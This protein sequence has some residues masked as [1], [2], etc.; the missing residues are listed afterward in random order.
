MISI[1]RI[2]LIAVCA[3]AVAFAAETRAEDSNVLFNAPGLLIKKPKPGP[4]DVKSQPLA[5]P[6]LD[7]G[8]VL[9]RS[10]ADLNRLGLRR[11]GETVDGS[12]DCQVIRAPTGIAIVQRKGPGKTEVTTNDPRVPASGWTDA[13]LPEKAPSGAKAAAR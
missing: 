13:W 4:P 9:C 3:G 11:S 2:L 6:R 5:W 1:P 7:P 10:E 8:A 12:I